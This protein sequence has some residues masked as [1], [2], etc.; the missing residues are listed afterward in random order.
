MSV[1]C[2]RLRTWSAGEHRNCSPAR[3]RDRGGSSACAVVMGLAGRL[4]EC[5]LLECAG[6]CE[7][8]GE[9]QG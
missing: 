5:A 6:A 3:R 9:G 8:G 7:S 1:A 4:R 2:I